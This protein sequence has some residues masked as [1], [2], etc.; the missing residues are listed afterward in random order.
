ML[1]TLILAGSMT[2]ISFA[3]KAHEFWISPT[4]FQVDAGQTVSANLIVGTELVG[5]GQAYLPNR[6]RRFDYISGEMQANVRGRLGDRPATRIKD[7]P[8]GLMIIVHETA[9]FKITWDAFS[10][11]VAF[12]EHKDAT[13]TLE[14]HKERGLSEVDVAEVYSR[15]A[16]SLIGVGSAQGSD[17]EVG[18]ETEILALENPYTD[19]M[20][21][22]MDVRLLYQGEVR[23][24]EQIEIFE[25]SPD[26]AIEISTL[27]TNAAGVATIP[28]KPGHR[29]MLD[30]VVLRE[31]SAELA[32]SLGVVWESLWANLT[33]GVPAN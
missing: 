14:A 25:Q 18:L 16:K 2:C 28:V 12:V 20:A 32:E 17:R 22:G 19:E 30:A 1:R 23:G 11:F 7:A 4:E 8:D 9:D 27:R 15:Y 29:Y 31:P 6:F 33:F 10:E 21:D 13:W 3:A 26:G 24:D 5:N